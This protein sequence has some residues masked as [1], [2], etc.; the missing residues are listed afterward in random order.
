MGHGTKWGAPGSWR[1]PSVALPPPE[2]PK[3]SAGLLVA[4]RRGPERSERGPKEQNGPQEGR[5]GRPLGQEPQQVPSHRRDQCLL[6]GV[7]Q[8][9]SHEPPQ[10]SVLL[11]VAERPFPPLP[12]DLQQRTEL[13]RAHPLSIRLDQLLMHR[14]A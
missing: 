9:P 7:I 4:V 3:L 10:P 13:R 6:R 1:L 8:P 2:T 11:E 12:P 5:C 14:H